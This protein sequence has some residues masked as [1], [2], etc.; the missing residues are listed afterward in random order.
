MRDYLVLTRRVASC[1]ASITVSASS[2][3]IFISDRGL[4]RTQRSSPHLCIER[5]RERKRETSRR[6][7]DFSLNS[8]VAPRSAP[9][10]RVAAMSSPRDF[11]LPPIR[12][13]LALV[14]VFAVLSHFSAVHHSEAYSNRIS[15]LRSYL[16]LGSDGMPLSARVRLGHAA[17]A[18]AGAGV[19]KDDGAHSLA[20]V[21]EASAS[22]ARAHFCPVRSL[23]ELVLTSLYPHWPGRRAACQ[24]DSGPA[25]Q[26]HFF[27]PRAQLGPVGHTQEHPRN[28]GWARM[29]AL[30]AVPWG[31][32]RARAPEIPLSLQIASTGGITTLTSS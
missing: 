8:D 9:R 5:R 13:V 2:C 17:A 22:R 14:G 26:R 6:T 7:G 11:P 23:Y 1:R 3:S 20:F 30:C 27:H 19:V 25:S 21:D 4:V 31:L 16:G 29:T 18:A 32:T 10:S 15:A 28:G 12:A 24:L